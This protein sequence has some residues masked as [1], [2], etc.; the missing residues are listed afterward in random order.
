[1]ASSCFVSLQKFSTF[2][3]VTLSLFVGLVILGKLSAA[4][5]QTAQQLCSL[6]WL[7]SALTQ[8]PRENIEAQHQQLIAQMITHEVF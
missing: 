2:I 7:S 6:S 5:A 1:M 8:I 4:R 3:T